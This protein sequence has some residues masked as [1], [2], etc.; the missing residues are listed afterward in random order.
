PLANGVVFSGGRLVGEEGNEFQEAL[1]V[2][3]KKYQGSSSAKKAG[4]YLKKIFFKTLKQHSPKILSS[5]QLKTKDK[6]HLTVIQWNGPGGRTCTSLFFSRLWKGYEV[7]I[8]GVCTKERLD[9]TVRELSLAAVT[10]KM[11]KSWKP[12]SDLAK[13]RQ[14]KSAGLVW[15]MAAPQDFEN[16]PTP[17]GIV[18]TTYRSGSLEL[19]AWMSTKSELQGKR[20]ALVYAHGGFAY[21]HEDWDVV[22][23]FVKKGF[24]VMLP[25]YRAE[26]GNPGHYEMFYGEV[27]DLIAAGKHLSGLP[28]VDK[29]RV[30]L[31]GHSTGGTLSILA[32]M[33]NSPFKSVVAIGG[34]LNL[35]HVSPAFR[36]KQEKSIFF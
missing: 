22:E 6:I 32:A 35:A 26:N 20:P 18:E 10:A 1:N 33:M 21:G 11:E 29:N 2:F 15:E 8:V 30:Y 14:G 13:A 12:V 17:K 4:E 9:E 3:A 7:A 27:D 24:V 31:L 28:N 5:A 23:G 36:Q 19:K 34:N 16:K 25:T